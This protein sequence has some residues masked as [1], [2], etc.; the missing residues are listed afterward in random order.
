MTGKNVPKDA[1][2]G[3]DIKN[4]SGKDVRNNSLT[5]ADIRDLLSGD[6]ANGALLAEDFTPGQLP[7]GAQ[8]AKGD[9]GEKGE[10]GD[11]GDQG[12]AGAT[13][14]VVRWSGFGAAQPGLR[15]EGDA[16]GIGSA[17]TCEG[18]GCLPAEVQGVT[19]MALIRGY[20]RLQLL[21]GRRMYLARWEWREGEPG[22]YGRSSILL[23]HRLHD[24]ERSQRIRHGDGRPARRRCDRRGAGRVPTRGACRRRGVST[25]GDMR[26]A[27]VFQ[28]HPVARVGENRDGSEVAMLAYVLCAAP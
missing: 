4:L 2:T 19:R 11:Q 14:V 17:A 27:I 5:G 13:N 26:S 6:V 12:A 20:R 23:G 18:P 22:W 3:A 1:L 8:G 16:G 24:T 10:Q 15:P 7:S 9:K 21:R 25:L 28:N